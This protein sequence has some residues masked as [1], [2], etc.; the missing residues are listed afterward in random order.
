MGIGIWKIYSNYIFRTWK[1]GGSCGTMLSKG[2][3]D[4]LFILTTDPETKFELPGWQ[5]TVG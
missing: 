4:L 3:V 2:P 1:I 5:T